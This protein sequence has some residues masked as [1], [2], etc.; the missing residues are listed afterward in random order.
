M[1][2]KEYNYLIVGAGLFGATFACMVRRRS[3]RCLVI[4]KRPARSLPGGSA[5]T[6]TTTWT[7]PCRPH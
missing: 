1:K 5:L 4:D 3:K 2:R 7:G 6:N